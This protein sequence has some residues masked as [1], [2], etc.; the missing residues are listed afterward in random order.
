[1]FG[2]FA[3]DFLLTA[4]YI[5]FEMENTAFS[6]ITDNPKITKWKYMIVYSI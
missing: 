3:L 6:K 1:M 5:Y 2:F 4:L